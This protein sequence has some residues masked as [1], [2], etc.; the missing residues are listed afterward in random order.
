MHFLIV[1]NAYLTNG[2]LSQVWTL[3][4]NKG[5]VWPRWPTWARKYF[6]QYQSNPNEQLL[7]HEIFTKGTSWPL[8]QGGVWPRWP[9][10]AWNFF[11]NTK[12]T[13]MNNFCFMKFSPK[14]LYDPSTRV[15]CDPG[16]PPGLEKKFTIL[17]G[18]NQLGS[19][20]WKK[21]KFPSLGTR[22]DRPG[23]PGPFFPGTGKK[24][25]FRSQH[26]LGPVL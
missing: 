10:W 12:A 4:H 18:P 26:F 7:F 13:L 6:F 14:W 5:G 2:K 17:K 3:H 16:G 8:N 9:T 23:F 11:F 15:R 1:K 20:L 22:P 19:I 24:S 25:K 21:S